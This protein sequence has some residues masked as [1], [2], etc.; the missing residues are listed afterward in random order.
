MENR[1]IKFRVFCEKHN[2][3]EYYTLGDLVCGFSMPENGE[4]G[5]FKSGTW[6]QFTGLYDKNGKEIYEGDIVKGILLYP[7]GES[8]ALPT[9]GAVEYF[10]GYAAFCICNDAGQTLFEHHLINSFEIIGN[11]YENPEL[12]K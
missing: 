2:K 10:I 5:I 11:L 12:I 7:T 1:I 6:A 4:G 3:W 9:M 8:V